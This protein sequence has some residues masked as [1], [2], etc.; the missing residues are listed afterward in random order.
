MTS[1]AVINNFD[2]VDALLPGRRSAVILP[3]KYL[4]NLEI[5]KENLSNGIIPAI[6]SFAHA[7]Q[8]SMFLEVEPASKR[9]PEVVRLE[10]E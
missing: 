9:P 2:I 7:C 10:L 5:A 4:L 6:T 1:F 3:S 8:N